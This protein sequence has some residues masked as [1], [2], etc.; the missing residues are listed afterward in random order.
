MLSALNWLCAWLISRTV[1]RM[2]TL[3]AQGKSSFDIRN[4]LQVFNASS[5]SVAYGEVRRALVIYLILCTYI[6]I[7][8][9]SFLLQRSIF[10]VFHKF[11]NDLN[12]SNEKKV[13]SKLLS[14]YGANLIVKH[15]GLYYEV[16]I[17]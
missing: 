17:T 13:L 9:I 15:L 6:I 1:Q 7:I 12:E 10:Y 3:K 14:F 4:D 11:V 5:L 16:K 2:E 8:F